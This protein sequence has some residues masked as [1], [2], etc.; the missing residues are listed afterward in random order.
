VRDYLWIAGSAL[1]LLGGLFEL[2]GFDEAR[3]VVGLALLC[4]LIV[5]TARAI[6][7]RSRGQSW[8]DALWG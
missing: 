8:S 7:R 1:L 5:L 4:V 6:G 3:L 2:L